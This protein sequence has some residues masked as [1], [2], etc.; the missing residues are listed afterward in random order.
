MINMNNMNLTSFITILDFE[1]G[2]VVQYQKHVKN[3]LVFMHDTD[4]WIEI[5]DF[6]A[7]KGHGTGIQWMVHHG[8]PIKFDYNG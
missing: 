4:K 8:E 2:E 5:E 6:L 1:L 3:D 7:E